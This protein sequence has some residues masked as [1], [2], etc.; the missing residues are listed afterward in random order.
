MEW[1]SGLEWLY[2]NTIEHATDGLS[3]SAHHSVEDFSN[4]TLDGETKSSKKFLTT[5]EQITRVYTKGMLRGI[6]QSNEL[7]TG[8]VSP[9]R[10]SAPLPTIDGSKFSDNLRALLS[11]HNVSQKELAE[12]IGT[13]ETSM[14]RYV[15]GE[16]KPNIEVAVKIANA[17]GVG[18]EELVRV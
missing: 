5:N 13:T 10:R 9:S 2:N 4:I 18:I 17:L 8:F 11:S 1:I 6:K 7:L 14:S 15:N 12:K 16:R 3:P